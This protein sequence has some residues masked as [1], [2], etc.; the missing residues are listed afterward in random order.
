MKPLCQWQHYCLVLGFKACGE[1]A[2]FIYN[3]KTYLCS[4]HAVYVKDESQLEFV[5]EKKETK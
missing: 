5:D 3:N 4:A 1:K 2:V